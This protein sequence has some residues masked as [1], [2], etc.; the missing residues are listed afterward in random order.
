MLKQS[1]PA[2]QL[3][4]LGEYCKAGREYWKSGRIQEAET[5]FLSAWEVIPD[6]KCSHDYAQSLSRGMVDFLKETGQFDKAIQWLDVMHEA[7]A[8][9]ICETSFDYVDFIAGTVY[10]D[11]G[12]VASAYATF[13]RHYDAHGKRPFMGEDKKYLAFYLEH[14]DTRIGS[15]N[16]P[17]LIPTK[18]P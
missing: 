14:R 6:P 16:M 2:A 13:K 9:D 15:G 7:Y 11:A 1:L 17:P 4:Q 10:L 3:Q 18:N 5:C 8:T 12:D